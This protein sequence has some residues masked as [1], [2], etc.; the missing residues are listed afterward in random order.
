MKPPTFPNLAG[1]DELARRNG[2]DTRPILV[3]VLTDLYVQK[4]TH[5]AEEELHYTQLVLG[6]LDAVDVRTRAIVANKLADYPA[7][8]ADVV[9]RLARDVIEVAEPLLQR[10]PCLTAAELIAIIDACGMRHVAA[11]AARR[12]REPAGAADAINEAASGTLQRAPT[13][14]AAANRPT[15]SATA[16]RNAR[17]VGHARS[18]APVDTGLG[19]LFLAASS[20]QRRVI[21]ANLQDDARVLLPP[22][23]SNRVGAVERLE[24]AALARE[25]QAFVR[26]LERAL[27]LSPEH[28]RRI[29]EDGTGEPLLVG[30]KALGTA[31]EVLQRILLFINPA[32]GHSVPRVFDLATLYERLAQGAA[33]WLIASLTGAAPRPRATHQPVLWDDAAESR[34]FAREPTRRSAAP[35]KAPE[36]RDGSTPP[37]RHHG[38]M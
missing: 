17:A 15:A 35:A 9:R 11:I 32:I 19:E 26:E 16:P 33:Q 14:P 5:T 6:L 22:L 23:P 12:R 37:G 29:A 34:R 4:P 7:A 30:L 31:P 8:P 28:A 3:R 24:A 21:L 13:R 18:G 20:A 10:S 2:V 27:G 36:R 1:L 38:T 25:P